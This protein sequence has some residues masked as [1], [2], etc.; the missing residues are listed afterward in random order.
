[1]KEVFL[2]VVFAI[3]FDFALSQ[4]DDV[5][6]AKFIVIRGTNLGN[7]DPYTVPWTNIKSLLTSSFY[8]NNKPTIVFAH[9]YIDSYQSS[10]VQGIIQAYMTKRNEFNIFIIDW[11]KYSDGNYFLHAIPNVFKVRDFT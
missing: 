1:M 10:S 11:D 8:D 7:I 9:G 3:S 2:F 6:D 5:S 4:C